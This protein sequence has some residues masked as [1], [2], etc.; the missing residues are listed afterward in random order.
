[1]TGRV[2]RSIPLENAAGMILPQRHADAPLLVRTNDAS[3]AHRTL[4][5]KFLRAV[6]DAWDSHGDAVLDRLALEHP[7]VFAP[8]VAR[9]VQVC[10]RLICIVGRTSGPPV[11]IFSA[12]S[13]GRREPGGETGRQIKTDSNR[14]SAKMLTRSHA[15]CLS[16]RPMI[17][18]SRLYGPA[19]AETTMISITA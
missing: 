18:A 4:S 5:T 2:G 12:R 16:I 17:T 7:Q 3:K 14:G 9:L 15:M 8:M 10:Q 19:P 6:N 11:L 13:A 1:M